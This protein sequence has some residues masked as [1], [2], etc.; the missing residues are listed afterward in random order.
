VGRGPRPRWRALPIVGP[1]RG[2]VSDLINQQL[3]DLVI[4]HGYRLTFDFDRL[5]VAGEP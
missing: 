1:L 5:T 3:Y 4:D 2:A